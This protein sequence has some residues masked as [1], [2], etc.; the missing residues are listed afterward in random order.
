MTLLI[1]KDHE[2][3][4]ELDLSFNDVDDSLCEP[5]SEIIFKNNKL[6]KMV[7]WHS[8]LT[9]EP[10]NKLYQ[11]LKDRSKYFSSLHIDLHGS[12]FVS[13]ETVEL[14]EEEFNA[15]VIKRFG[16]RI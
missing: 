10:A 11:A 7:L 6:Q 3:L 1:F 2:T 12:K 16:R 4:L 8:C 5:I 9:E 14:F 13:N 15:K